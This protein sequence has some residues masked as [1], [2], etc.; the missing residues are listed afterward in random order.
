M[1]QEKQPQVLEKK[2]RSMKNH[3][4]SYLMSSFFYDLM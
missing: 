2:L 1:E 4:N 3:K